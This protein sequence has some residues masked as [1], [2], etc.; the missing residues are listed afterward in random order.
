MAAARHRKNRVVL[1]L[2]HNIT[3]KAYINHMGGQSHY[4][5]A[6]AHYL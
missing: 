1:V 5:S 3:T 6:I 4:L 2:T